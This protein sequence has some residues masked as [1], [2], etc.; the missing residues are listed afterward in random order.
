MIEQSKEAFLR[1]WPSGQRCAAEVGDLACSEQGVGA[2]PA[3]GGRVRWAG[4]A[5]AG[6]PMPQQ[7]FPARVMASVLSDSKSCFHFL[8]LAFPSSADTEY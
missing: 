2:A 1:R 7:R 5:A 8:F 4:E 6:P 3:N